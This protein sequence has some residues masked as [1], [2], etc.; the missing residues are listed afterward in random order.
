M[1][2]KYARTRASTKRGNMMVVLLG[3]VIVIGSFLFAVAAFA[4]SEN[5]AGGAPDRPA[6][7]KIEGDF[8]HTYTSLG[9]LKGASSLIVLATVQSQSVVY[10]KRGVPSTISTVSIERVQKGAA[11]HTIG[12]KQMGGLGRDGTQWEMEN[13]PLLAKGTRYLLFLTPS[14]TPDV[15]YP[16]GAPQ[17]V[18]I[19]SANGAV[20]PLNAQLGIPVGNISVDQLINDVQAAIEIPSQP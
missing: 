9:E 11:G 2:K 15:Y 13:F 17:G 20:I 12:V 4:S 10:N 5:N 8:A 3:G 6:V 19:A 14:P 18:Y 1:S 7:T 16:V